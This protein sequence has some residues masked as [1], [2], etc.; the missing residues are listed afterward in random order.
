MFSAVLFC[1]TTVNST[2]WQE[3][4][5]PK[6]FAKLNSRDYQSFSG[7]LKNK[8]PANN[9]S[10]SSTVSSTSVA[11]TD[12]QTQD[13]FTVMLYTHMTDEALVVGARNILYKLSVDELRLKQT[14]TWNSVELDRDSCL[15]KGNN[16]EECQ[17]YIKVLQQYEND[18]DRY[19]ICG[20]NA[21]KPSCRIYVDERGSYV[22]REPFSGLGLAPFSPWH[23][24]TA[25]LVDED[26]YSG[27]VA[28][29]TG[30]DPIIFKKPLRTQQYDSTQ[31]NSPDFV[32]SF[33]HKDFVYFFLREGA[34]EH[35]NC[36]KTVFSRVAR[37]CKHDEG[38]PNKNKNM[39]TSFLKARLNCSVPGDYPFYFN[40]IQSVSQLIEG[41]YGQGSIENSVNDEA[42]TKDAILYATFSTPPNSIGGSAVCAFRLREV[43]DAF[44]GGF[45]EQRDMSANWLPVPENQVPSNP[46]PG[47]CHNDTKSLSDTYINFIKTHTLMD[48]SIP[49]FFGSPVLIRTGLVSRFTS[50]AV[51]PQVGTTE[52]KTYDVIFVGTT[53]GRVIKTINAQSAD[54]REGVKTVVIEE[55]QVFDSNV[56][57]K[58]LKVMGGGLAGRKS[59]GRLG[60][61]SELEIRSL[62]V[63]RCDRATNCGDCVALQDPYCAWDVRAS[64]C[65]SG[66]WTSNMAN[67]YLQ[68]VVSGK[69]PQCPQLTK[70][71]TAS[72]TTPSKSS[73]SQKDDGAFLY[74]FDQAPLG[75]V[76]N[77]V[78]NHNTLE[79]GG[80]FRTSTGHGGGQTQIPGAN[81][82][83]SVQV[84]EASQALFSLETLIITVSAGAV[85]AL[86]V[87]FVTGYCCGRRC[88][89][90][91]NTLVGHLGYPDTEYEYFEQ[92]GGLARPQIMHAGGGVGPPLPPGMPPIG[93]P[94]A[95]LLPQETAKLDNYPGNFGEQEEVTYA[96]P[97]LLTGLQ[98]YSGGPLMGSGGPVGPGVIGMSGP[99]SMPNS[100]YVGIGQGSGGQLPGTTNSGPG[101]HYSSSLL[102]GPNKFNTIHSSVNKRSNSSAGA[103]A[104]NH[105]ES[106]GPMGGMPGG[107]PSLGGGISGGP[108]N[109]SGGNGSAAYH[110]STLGRSSSVRGRDPLLPTS[111]G[112][113]VSTAGSG[114]SGGLK[115]HA[116][117]AKVVDSAYGTT[118]SSKKVYL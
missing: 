88:H 77:I 43:S 35:T 110:M 26:L 23:N 40:E 6:L 34:V 65:S 20:T 54:S 83:N 19:L 116:Q 58:E 42:K 64:R 7:T 70:P 2:N 38:G 91:D 105:Y 10:S 29:F 71:N 92:R 82:D 46:R 94:G 4:I 90:D 84:I 32:G 11:G 51:D 72:A 15:V 5:R 49:P 114:Q 103:S 16:A 1:L 62:S 12:S 111:S 37:V 13:F 100:R 102:S 33:S 9:A 69:H 108:P 97:E 98:G 79:K 39:W 66:D 113:S 18:P 63:Q 8:S 52:G 73:R 27:T 107:R 3:N 24:S 95:P 61:M 30:V 55:L 60:V 104:L 109:S 87:G 56:V 74:G 47:S 76:V 17:N 101:S 59:L 118:R 81:G 44:S 53:K 67:S 22:M 68:A 80:H 36:G 99:I 78:D 86:V 31:L 21:Y 89:K 48:D 25:V 85:A 50:I 93:G 112:S 57:I 117:T 45:K 14:L 115:N 96:E 75:Q 28:D 106:A 41:H